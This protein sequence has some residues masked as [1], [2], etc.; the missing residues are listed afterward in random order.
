MHGNSAFRSASRSGDRK[1]EALRMVGLLVGKPVDGRHVASS[2]VACIHEFL[3][4]APEGVSRQRAAADHQEGN[5]NHSLAQTMSTT[6]DDVP[7]NSEAIQTDHAVQFSGNQ[8]DKRPDQAIVIGVDGRQVGVDFARSR[9]H[10]HH[11]REHHAS[12]DDGGHKL[13]KPQ[14]GIRV[15]HNLHMS[16]NI[17]ELLVG[18]REAAQSAQ[19]MDDHAQRDHGHEKEMQPNLFMSKDRGAAGNLNKVPEKILAEL[20]GARKGHVAE[21]EQAKDSA[22]DGLGHVSVC[23]P[24]AGTLGITKGHA[25]NDFRTGGGMTVFDVVGSHIDFLFDF[26]LTGTRA[27]NAASPLVFDE[28]MMLLSDVFNIDSDQI[29]AA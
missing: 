26:Y 13:D 10:G 1:R 2:G 14:A 19:S 12:Q 15:M 18:S 21:Q 17:T 8:E 7:L 5:H 22:G 11:V 20:D 27:E 4:I 16:T 24:L 23:G 9:Q 6:L 28:R 29:F 25:G 3:T